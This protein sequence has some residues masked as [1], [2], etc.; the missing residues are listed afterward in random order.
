MPPG[1]M[2]LHDAIAIVEHELKQ[3]A[4]L[5]AVLAVDR[6][7]PRDV[8]GI[9]VIL[10]R[11]IHQDE[12][13]VLQPIGVPIVV[14][15]PDVVGAGRR[16]RAIA[17]E[18]RTAGQEDVAGDGVELIFEHARPGALH[19]LDQPPAGEL[20][21]AADQGDLARALDARISSRIGVRFV[22]SFLGN[23]ACRRSTR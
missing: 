11:E 13:A 23:R 18:A 15:V 12:V 20:R 10:R 5:G 21:G 3:L 22:T 8:A 19:G 2:P 1:R 17:L 9:V 7:D 16:D 4:L 14:H 6:P